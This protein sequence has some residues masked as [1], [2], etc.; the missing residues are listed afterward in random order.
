M[1]KMTGVPTRRATMAAFRAASRLGLSASA[2]PEI[3]RTLALA[4]YSGS[5]S[6]TESCRSAMQ[7]RYIK[8]ELSEGLS[9]SVN[10]RPSFSPPVQRVT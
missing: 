7:L 6:S 5:I 3:K 9:I 10:V 1:S 4:M 2:V 8:I